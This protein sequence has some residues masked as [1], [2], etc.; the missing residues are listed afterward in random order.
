MVTLG[1]KGLNAKLSDKTTIIEFTGHAIRDKKVSTLFLLRV[2]VGKLL[3][4]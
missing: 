3:Q 4:T 2:M 1:K